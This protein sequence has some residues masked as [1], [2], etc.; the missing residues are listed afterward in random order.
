MKTLAAR[1][2]RNLT[3][4]VLVAVALVLWFRG[5]AES[6]RPTA[7][8]SGGLLL[9]MCLFLAAYN[10][11]KKLPFLP[12]GR[13][14]TWMQWHIYV[15]WLSIVVF[16]L[17]A[18][19]DPATGWRLPSGPFE[20]LLGIVYAATA[21]SGVVG[22][23]LTRT[24]P[25]RLTSRGREFIYERIPALR[26]EARESAARLA[27]ESVDEAHASTLAD[28]YT[29]RLANFFSGPR[30]YWHHLIQSSRPR[31]RLLGQLRDL[32]RYL[33]EE[34]RVTRAELEQLICTKDD[35]DFHRALQLTLK[36]WLF[37][38][39]ALT[40]GLLAMVL[41]HVPIVYAFTGAS[42]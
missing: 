19:Y 26:R 2:I 29:E 16:L 13:S 30:H 35:L 21:L 8:L 32:D 14:A 23:F 40:Y 4:A 6:L 25:V 18:C 10:V 15:G 17:H 39:I 3:V 7:F 38:H 36:G 27:L 42:M 22:L 34:Q 20:Q 11:R 33:S 37:V 5:R 31:Q 1:R 41:V 9:G 24:I 28:F 12:L